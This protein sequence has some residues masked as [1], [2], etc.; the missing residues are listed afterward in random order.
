MGGGTNEL[1]QHKM[2]CIDLAGFVSTMKNLFIDPS[3][4]FW[5]LERKLL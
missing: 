5:S 2:F 3:D 1:A 4:H